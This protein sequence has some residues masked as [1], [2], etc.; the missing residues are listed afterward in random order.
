M[1]PFLSISVFSLGLGNENWP[2]Q[3]FMHVRQNN[4]EKVH[5]IMGGSS[6]VEPNWTDDSG[7]GFLYLASLN[8]YD[9]LVGFLLAQGCVVDILNKVSRISTVQ[10]QERT[11]CISVKGV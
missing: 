5:E 8:G 3:L 2:K 7:N 6:P 10:E 11:V 1:V 4:Q 9:E